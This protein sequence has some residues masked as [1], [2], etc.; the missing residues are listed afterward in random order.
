[1]HHISTLLC[2]VAKTERK[3]IMKKLLIIL[4]L[5]LA[6]VETFA[7]P[8]TGRVISSEDSYAIEGAYVYALRN[9]AIIAQSVS[10]REGKFSLSVKESGDYILQAQMMGFKDLQVSLTNIHG[11]VDLG[12]L[13]M[14][15]SYQMLGEVT[16]QAENLVKIDRQIYFPPSVAV[17][18][19]FNGL[20]LLSKLRLPGLLVN[21]GD[22]SITAVDNRSLQIRINGVE[23]EM[24]D[25]TALKPD[26]IQKVEYIDMPGVRYGDVGRVIDIITKRLESGFSTS[27]TLRTAV[28]APN[29][30]SQVNFKYNHK[31]SEYG[32]SYNYNYSYYK[33]RY[34]NNSLEIKL[35]DEVLTLN[36][37]GS[38]APNKS[39]GHNLTFTYN[40]RND[41][42]TMF[43]AVLRN[44]WNLPQLRVKQFVTDQLNDEF[45]NYYLHTKDHTYTPSLNLYFEH[46]IS[47]KQTIIANMVGSYINTDYQRENKEWSENGD[48]QRDLSY[49]TKGDK[50]TYQGELL[51]ENNFNQ[52][53]QLTVGVNYKW[54]KAKN[55][56]SESLT[57]KM[58]TSDLYG[59]AQLQGSIKKFVYQVGVGFTHQSFKEGDYKY[60]KSLLRPQMTLSYSPLKNLNIRYN[61]RM[62]P[63]SPSL[64]QT[65]EFEQWINY[66][67]MDKG[68]PDLKPYQV[69]VNML[70][71]DWRIKR[72]SID[73]SLY[74]QFNNNYVFNTIYRRN[75]GNH[76][77]IEYHQENQKDY[78]HIQPRLFLTYEAVKNHL[79]IT[80]FGVIN[81]YLN[82]GNVYTRCL[83]SPMWGAQLDG[84]YMNW[85]LSASYL[86]KGKMQ[87][88]ELTDF[89]SASSNISLRYRLK[90]LQFGLDVLNIFQ[91]KGTP[92]KDETISEYI[93]KKSEIVTRN[94]GNMV[95]FSISWNFDSGRKY[96]IG[97]KKTS[98]GVDSDS[99]VMK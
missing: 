97:S 9:G 3:K 41:K 52:Q 31:H 37:V 92:H 45:Y 62:E 35:P 18:N 8:I 98:N 54:S 75:D 44:Q 66:Y 28:T 56:Y 88:A 94:M 78:Q 93:H 69:Y 32:M 96:R 1:M 79:N 59:Y 81:R 12:D 90:Q 68:N 80:V 11:K 83:T 60:H 15:I 40:W 64:S 7:F 82:H 47:Q 99:G 50:Q 43:N 95:Q 4:V 67:E 70:T 91:P 46:P 22:N 23:V 71:L 24:S 39:L 73:L 77:Y 63:G 51:Y 27:G 30:S 72:L 16:V 20:E 29:V 5:I 58:I 6:C 17:E 26:R 85:S 86:S 36:R 76:Y 13:T 10:D 34:Q 65:S 33:E 25:V 57:N 14:I 89:S 42:G 61:V 2:L 38:N 55:V 21:I 49:T 87:R 19:S 53:A 74:Y 48:I 84:N